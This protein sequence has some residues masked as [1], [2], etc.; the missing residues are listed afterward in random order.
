MA[1][2]KKL[3]TGAITGIV[4]IAIIVIIILWVIGAY[5]GLVNADVNVDNAW[6]QVE[7]A[8]QRR[9]DLI[10]NL[11]ATVQGAADFEQETLQNIVEARSAW[12]AAKTPEEQ[13]NAA[14]GLE[15]AL[16]R[17]LVVVERYPDIKATHFG[18][19]PGDKKMAP[20][21]GRITKPINNAIPTK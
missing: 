18:S 16:G 2:K 11:V 7:T 4:A 8:Y 3:S 19:Q 1:K 6:G 17:L 13:V 12:A 15:S 21:K 10:P 20:R 14:N 5:N 9:A